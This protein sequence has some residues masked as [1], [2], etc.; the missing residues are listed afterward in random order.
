MQILIIIGFQKYS[1]NMRECQHIQYHTII[2][3]LCYLM[4]IKEKLLKHNPVSKEMR[5]KLVI[6]TQSH[7]KVYNKDFYVN[8][9][10]TL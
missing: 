4:L 7:I 3:K 10:L 6:V 8:L 5:T 9:V 2:I 1:G